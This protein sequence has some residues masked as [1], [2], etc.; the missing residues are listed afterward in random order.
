[1]VFLANQNRSADVGEFF[2]DEIPLK[3]VVEAEQRTIWQVRL[4][5]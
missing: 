4:G 3:H 2:T 5:S 1:M